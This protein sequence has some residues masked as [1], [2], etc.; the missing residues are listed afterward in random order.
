MGA[1]RKSQIMEEKEK[2]AT[3]Y[4]EVSMIVLVT[5]GFNLDSREDIRW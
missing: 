3:A 4:H 1:E 5:A 2:L